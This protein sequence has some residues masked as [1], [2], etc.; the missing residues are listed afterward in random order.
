MT[1]EPA[2]ASGHVEYMYVHVGYSFKVIADVLRL[3]NAYLW[4]K[5]CASI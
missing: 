3:I 4:Q 5:Y 2:M 1:N